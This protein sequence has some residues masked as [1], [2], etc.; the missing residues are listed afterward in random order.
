MGSKRRI[1]KYILPIILKNR[2]DNQCYVEPFVGG[3]NTIDGVGGFRI[4]ADKNR[5]VISLLNSLKNGWLPP[6][7]VDKELYEKVKKNKDEYSEE[8]VGYFGTQLTFGS[9]WFGSFRRDN[10]GKRKYDVEAYENVIEQQPKLKDI[11][12]IYSDYKSLIIPDKS[13]IYCD[14]PYKGSRTFIGDNKINHVEFWEWC[15]EKSKIGHA[16]YVSE[17]SAPEDFDCIWSK[18][19]VV[20]GNNIHDKKLTNTEKL[21]V[22]R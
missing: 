13:I 10:T 16:V 21:F 7:N 2:K 14:P 3:A 20:S 5:Y 15:R 11:V 22:L 4:G 8:I 9:V 19:I 1:A 17:Y 18:E 12:F 6:R